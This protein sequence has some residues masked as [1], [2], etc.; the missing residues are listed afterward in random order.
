MGAAVAAGT[1]PA[2]CIYAQSARIITS[3]TVSPHSAAR[4]VAAVYT[5][6]ST[7][8]VFNSFATSTVYIHTHLARARRKD[9]SHESARY[10]ILAGLSCRV[11]R[12]G[13]ACRLACCAA[14]MVFSSFLPYRVDIPPMTR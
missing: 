7:R 8:Y 11:L 2:A 4:T 13:C 1:D 12:V 9:G 3:V 14:V 10:R 5:S 6:P